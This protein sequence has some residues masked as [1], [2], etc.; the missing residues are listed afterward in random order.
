LPHAPLPAR[1]DVYH[2]V[3]F[4]V[5]RNHRNRAAGSGCTMRL[6]LISIHAVQESGEA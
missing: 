1:A 3:E 5:T 4:V 6:V 2:R